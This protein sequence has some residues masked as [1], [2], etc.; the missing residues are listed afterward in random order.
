MNN[1]P[2]LTEN[3]PVETDQRSSQVFAR[4]TQGWTNWITQVF[5]CLPWRNGFNVTA[6]LNI[7]SAAAGAQASIT[8]SDVT[9]IVFTGVVTADN[10]V[11]VYAKNFTVGAIDPSSQVYRI[12]VLQN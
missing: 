4:L 6:T 10:T 5:L 2:P 8:T 1:R 9:G 3:L 11:T 12:I 7:G